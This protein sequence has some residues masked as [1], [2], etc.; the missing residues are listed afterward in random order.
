VVSV[1]IGEKGSLIF[2]SSAPMI[3]LYSQLKHRH[4]QLVALALNCNF[5]N[6]KCVS[7]GYSTSSL[8]LRDL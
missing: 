6:N 2:P 1:I 3:N 4:L 5:E 7:D 8:E